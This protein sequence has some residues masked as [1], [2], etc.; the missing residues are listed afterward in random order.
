[1][2]FEEF[3]GSHYEGIEDWIQFV[4]RTNKSSFVPSCLFD[5]SNR[6]GRCSGSTPVN[7]CQ[8]EKLQGIK[9][10]FLCLAY[11]DIPPGLIAL[12]LALILLV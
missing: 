11:A 6:I 7:F 8:T 4:Q 2:G 5:V 10:L 9:D 3:S 12:Y 1:M